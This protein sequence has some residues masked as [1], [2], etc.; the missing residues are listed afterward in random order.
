MNEYCRSGKK[1]NGTEAIYHE[2]GM[3]TQKKKVRGQY[4]K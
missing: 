1:H 2:S 4:S 3:E